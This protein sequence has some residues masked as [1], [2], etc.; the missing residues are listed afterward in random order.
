[1]ERSRWYIGTPN[2]VVM[3]VDS[4]QEHQPQ[5]RLYHA[6]SREGK[7]FG[8]MEQLF[9]WLE[10]FYNWINFPYPGT[11]DRTFAE[12]KTKRARG[13]SPVERT[14]MMNDEELLSRHGDMGTFVI[15][16]Q[17]RQNSSWQGRITWLDRDKTVYFRSVWELMKLVDGALDMVCGTEDGADE[18]SWT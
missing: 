1:M 14:K 18:V 5:G 7:R 16:V 11:V 10:Q 8:T 9:S 17:H 12:V 3:C 15:R 4:R 13:M 6:Y 2:G